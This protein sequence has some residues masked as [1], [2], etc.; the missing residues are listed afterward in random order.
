MCNMAA[1]PWIDR[2]GFVK[3]KLMRYQ[4]QDYCSNCEKKTLFAADAY[5]GCFIIGM[6]GLGC[7][8]LFSK[9]ILIGIIL[10]IGVIVLCSGESPML[11]Q[12]C[13]TDQR[14]SRR[15]LQQADSLEHEAPP[16]LSEAEQ[17]ALEKKNRSRRVK[18]T[19]FCPSCYV[20]LDY[21]RADNDGYL[22][23]SQCHAFLKI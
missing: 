14:V 17:Q 4:E 18:H 3:I 9:L 6:L 23:C 2:V 10:I 13:G 8:L 12:I 7:L 16:K 15:K 22:E 21:T 20:P 11:C 5:S 1:R 19:G